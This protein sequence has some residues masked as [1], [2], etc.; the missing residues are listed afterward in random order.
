[1][2]SFLIFILFAIWLYR[3]YQ[4]RKMN[5]RKFSHSSYYEAVYGGDRRCTKQVLETLREVSGAKEILVNYRLLPDKEEEPGSLNGQE[6]PDGGNAGQNKFSNKEFHENLD[7]AELILIHETGIYLVET[8][9]YEGCISGE[10]QDQYWIQNIAGSNEYTGYRNYFYNPGLK[11]RENVRKLRRILSGMP[12]LLYFSVVVFSDGCVLD[13]E[14]RH[15]G[16]EKERIT[17]QGQL[18]MTLYDLIRGA[19]TFLSPQVVEQI[20]ERLS[21]GEGDKE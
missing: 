2:L 5:S 16:E 18:S 9:D 1:M 10:A 20:Y 7:V 3:N 12:W 15:D 17:H 13:V 8:R 19:S 21:G 4:Y 6:E 11:N 14:E